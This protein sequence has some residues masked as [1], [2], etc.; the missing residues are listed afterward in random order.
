MSEEA[1]K[2]RKKEQYRKE[3]EKIKINYKNRQI[4]YGVTII[5]YTSEN[6]KTFRIKDD[7]KNPYYISSLVIVKMIQNL[8][9]L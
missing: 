9:L 5:K 1:G 8:I 2:G 6:K 4:I 7:I 3:S